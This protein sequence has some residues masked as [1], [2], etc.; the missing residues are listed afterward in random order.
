MHK[1]RKYLRMMYIKTRSRKTSLY[2]VLLLRDLDADK[3]RLLIYDVDK[4]K[5]YYECRVYPDECS[6][7]LKDVAEFFDRETLN[8]IIKRLRSAGCKDIPAP[9]RSRQ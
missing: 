1:Y 6:Y 7:I 5:K 4:Q 8:I 3:V 9:K 2:Y